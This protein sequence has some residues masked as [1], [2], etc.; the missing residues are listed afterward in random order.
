MMGAG[1]S[2]V[3]RSLA[4]LS[5]RAFVDTDQLLQNR[6]GRSIT[7]IFQVYGEEAFRE[8]ETS[9]L[10]SLEP[11]ATVIST[12]GGVVLREENWAELRRLG[13]TVYLEASVETLVARLE[14]SK[15]KRP[16][17]EV[18][19][20]EDRLDEL[21]LARL[22]LY[23]QADLTLTLGHDGVDATAAQLL[24]LLGGTA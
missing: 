12:G 8:H 4:E 16:L 21:L 5:G 15:K 23:R 9:V 1:K 19:N 7:K 24:E 2:S 17:L 18:D 3:G 14:A 10:R 20:W 13:T 6:F 11:G 22:P